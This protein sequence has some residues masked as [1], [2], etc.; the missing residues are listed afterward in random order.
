MTNIL[1]AGVDSLVGSSLAKHLATQA[2]VSGLWFEDRTFVDRCPSVVVS[3]ESIADK[4]PAADVAVFCGGASRSS[5]DDQFGSFSAERN[6][7]KSLIAAASKSDARFVYVSSDAVFTGPWVFHGDETS[8]EITNTA[9]DKTA[10]AIVRFESQVAELSNSMIVRTNVLDWAPNSFLG[11][12]LDA[13]ISAGRLVL[14]ART[15]STPIFEQHFTPLLAECLNRDVTGYINIAGAERTSP[16]AF[17]TQLSNNMESAT[18]EL[19][20]NAMVK[21]TNERSLRCSRLRQELNL[22]AP[23]LKHMIEAVV[24][25]SSELATAAA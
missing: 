14:D 1:I 21:G 13:L 6:W 25:D 24:N 5:W 20:P 10:A 19:K 2:D 22:Q 16:F 4:V 15:Y 18:A 3:A 12:R 8:S 7:L 17:L 9:T 23:M 11:E